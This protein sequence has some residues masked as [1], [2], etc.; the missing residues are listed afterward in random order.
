MQEPGIG[1]A[2]A[3][4]IQ[5]AFELARRRNDAQEMQ[6]PTMTSSRDIC[7]LMQPL[8]GDLPHEE[9]WAIYMNKSH[10]IMDKK[11]ISQGGLSATVADVRIILKQAVSYLASGLVVCHNHPSG[12]LQ[13]SR[14]DRDLTEQLQQ[15]ARLFNIVLLDHVIIGE[16]GYYSFAD[17][18]DLFS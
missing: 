5:A 16:K 6:Q 2:K 18:G 11:R 3:V 7:R 12:N 10:R 9:F 1:T 17:H 4:S 13:P 14:M 8:I 15:A